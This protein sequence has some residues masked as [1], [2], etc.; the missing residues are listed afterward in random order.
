[1]AGAL[2]LLSVATPCQENA[3]SSKKALT[4]E[5][6]LGLRSLQDPQFS[7]DGSRVAFVV[8][9]PRTEEKRTRHIWIYEKAKNDSRQLTYSSKSESSPRWSPDGTQL[10]F[11]SN[12]DGE[13]QQI[14]LLRMQGGRPLR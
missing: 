13:E 7:P 3:G 14:Y 4:P 10:A 5:A 1:M 6:L 8:N 2:V 11:L 9:E 12:R